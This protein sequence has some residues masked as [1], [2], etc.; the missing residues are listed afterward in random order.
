VR[1][2]PHE[3]SGEKGLPGKIGSKQKEMH[4]IFTP[5]WGERDGAIAGSQKY[6]VWGVGQ[7]EE[8]RPRHRITEIGT[9]PE[10]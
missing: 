5:G 8:T 6:V 9:G 4:R 1:E 3:K 7:G 10:V 2:K